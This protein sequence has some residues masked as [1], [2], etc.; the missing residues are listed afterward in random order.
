ME[1][2]FQAVELESKTNKQ[3]QLKLIKTCLEDI[4]NQSISHWKKQAQRRNIVLDIVIPED[5]PQIVS[6]P[7][8]LTQALNGLMERF[9]RNLPS[10]SNFKVVIFPVG[11][12]LKLQFLAE[13]NYHNNTSKC[14]GKLLLFQP[15]TGNLSLSN[16][17]TKNLFHILGGKLIVKQKPNQGEVLTIFLP[18]NRHH[19][20]YQQS[21]D[22]IINQGLL[23]MQ[24]P[25][26]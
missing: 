9:I 22:N 2:I 3:E 14:L 1:L 24:T 13:S 19:K 23:T 5:L 20:Y 17:V 7:K 8:I 4:L 16:D 26:V 6:D 21:S 25:K 10:G 12:Q 18:L 15:E 11:N